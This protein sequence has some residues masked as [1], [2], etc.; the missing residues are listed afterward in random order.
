MFYKN[1]LRLFWWN[2]RKIQGKSQENYGDLL[3]K[4]LVEKISGKKVIYAF[5]T[6]FSFLDYFMPIYVTSGSILTHVN[7]KCVVWGSGIIAKEYQLKK[8][9]FLAVRGPESRKYLME[10][11]FE[12][13]E[14]YGDPGLLLS[15]Y[16]T[17]K[18]AKKYRFGVVPHYNDYKKI[19]DWFVNREDVLLISLMTN[20]IEETTN[21]IL[22]CE[23]IISSS[24]HGVIIAHAYGIPAIWQ[25]FTNK[26]FGDA[27]KYRD[28]FESV[29]I[30]PYVF[31]IKETP[32]L[33]NEMEELF[34]NAERILPKFGMVEKLQRELLNVCPFKS[35]I[36]HE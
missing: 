6:K 26:V 16:Y 10:Q 15:K 32:Y 33:A 9:K 14:V 36:H 31:P 7:H 20:N 29:E 30:D 8:A 24:L 17:P 18:I 34:E 2:E 22:Q 19:K 35:E 3:G 12:I 21:Q 5:P 11:G 25:Q 4:Y 13:P 27:I 28:Y 1:T 23:R